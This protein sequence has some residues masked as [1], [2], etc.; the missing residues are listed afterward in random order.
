MIPYLFQPAYVSGHSE[1]EGTRD[2]KFGS[3]G[4][5]EGNIPIITHTRAPPTMNATKT[6][7]RH[8]DPLDD[9]LVRAD[10]LDCIECL[11]FTPSPQPRRLDSTFKDNC[12]TE[13]GEAIMTN[14]F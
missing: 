8:R 4:K 10:I 14:K 9:R 11:E 5:R 13:G 7:A 3:C 12:R 6:K 2:C 1:A